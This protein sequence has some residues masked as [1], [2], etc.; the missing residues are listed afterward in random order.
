MKHKN[1]DAIL[2]FYLAK[3]SYGGWVTFA[4]HLYYGMEKVFPKAR[5]FKIGK[6]V[7]Q[8]LREFSG[9][10]G[11]QN[12]DLKT[13]CAL[14]KSYPTIIVAQDKHYSREFLRLSEYADLC[15]VHDHT[16]LTK[17]TEPLFKQMKIVTIR[18]AV[19][20]MLKEKGL[21]N[22]FIQHPYQKVAAENLP[23]PIHNAVAF[24]RIDWDKNTHIIAKANEQLP[25]DKWCHI[26]GKENRL[27]WFQ[28]IAPDAPRWDKYYHGAFPKAHGESFRTA[29]KGSF[30]VDLSLIKGDGG[31]SQYTFLEAWNARRPLVVHRNWLIPGHTLVEGENCL[32]VENNGELAE[33][34]QSDPQRYHDLAQNAWSMLS[35]HEPSFVSRVYKEIALS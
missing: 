30:A 7:E 25:E 32:A 1:K 13:A 18:Q 31:G 6:K 10:V 26:Y 35:K 33:L 4:E 23:D 12:I 15:V 27:Y 19:S 17:D 34:L 29:L 8:S 3:P 28:K 9:S 22:T 21:A 20:E 14:A 2:L 24:S 5:L 16:E 11:Y